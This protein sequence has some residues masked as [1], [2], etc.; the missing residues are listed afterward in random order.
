MEAYSLH[1]RYWCGLRVS[2]WHD[3]KHFNPVISKCFSTKVPA[4]T[5]QFLFLLPDA[6]VQVCVAFGHWRVVL[7]APHWTRKSHE[8]PAS[9][10]Q[11]LSGQLPLPTKVPS[12]R[13]LRYAFVGGVEYNQFGDDRQGIPAALSPQTRQHYSNHFDLLKLGN[14]YLLKKSKNFYTSYSF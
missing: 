8:P 2:N 1:M 6:Q 11:A 3:L 4:T 10:G 14:L 5:W 12:A 13:F 9:D 7:S